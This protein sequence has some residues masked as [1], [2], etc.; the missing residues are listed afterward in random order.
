M[1]EAWHV[2]NYLNQAKAL[3]AH[4]GWLDWLEEQG[5]QPKQAQMLM[6][7]AGIEKRKVFAFESVEA[8][9]ESAKK[10]HVYEATIRN[11]EPLLRAA[12]ELEPDRISELISGDV[13]FAWWIHPE[14]GNGLALWTA[15]WS[16]VCAWA[17]AFVRIES[18]AT[19]EDCQMVNDLHQAALI[20]ATRF[21]R[22]SSKKGS[23]A[24]RRV[25]R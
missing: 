2:G 9:L 17:D 16:A 5:A 19:E 7:L 3:V 4:G 11:P 24:S 8:A 20:L 10:P 6:K 18:D 14:G 15:A 23:E 1:E 25:R 22:C 12:K 21:L 13:T